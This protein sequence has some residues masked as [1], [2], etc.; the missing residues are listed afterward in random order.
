MSAS[1][2]KCD[3]DKRGGHTHDV[4]LA[5]SSAYDYEKKEREGEKE[6]TYNH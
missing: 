1:L 3:V 2:F 6:N 5:I 4:S